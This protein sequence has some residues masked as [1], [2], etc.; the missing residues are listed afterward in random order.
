MV[1]ALDAATSTF[2]KRVA[3]CHVILL[4]L[5]DADGFLLRE[6]PLS[7]SLLTND[8]ADIEG[9]STNASVQMTAAEY[10]TLVGT[11][12]LGAW[13]LAWNCGENP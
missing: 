10:R 5:Y 13:N 6:V 1:D 2:V 4:E 11:S 7:L 8:S 9:L 3:H 12:R